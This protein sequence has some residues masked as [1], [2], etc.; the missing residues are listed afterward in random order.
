[1]NH[2]KVN[3]LL[4]VVIPITLGF[5]AQFIW[6]IQLGLVCTVI[7]IILFMLNLPNDN[8]M[9]TNSDYQTKRVNPDY[10]I[11]KREISSLNKQN[12]IV[13]LLLAFLIILS[14]FVYIQQIQ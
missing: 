13:L 12:L 10:K 7:Y 4:I 5:I 14:F 6:S 8:F 3:L 2:A 1:L 11:K 9:S